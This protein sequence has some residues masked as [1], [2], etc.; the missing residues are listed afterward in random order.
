MANILVVDDELGI[1]DLLWEIL[2]D[3]GH[4]VEVAEYPAQIAQ[5]R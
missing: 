2:N 5:G 3:V 1:R 4:N